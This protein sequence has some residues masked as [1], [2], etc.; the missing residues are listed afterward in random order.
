M[1]VTKSARLQ[2]GATLIEALVAVLIFSIGILAVVGMQAFAVSAVSDA[3]YRADASFLA[4]QALGRLWG[5]PANLSVHAES[6]VD[7][8]GLPQGKR[9]VEISGERAVV[10]I[11]WQPPGGDEHRFVAEAHI[12]ANN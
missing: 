3:K 2:Q 6:D 7:V 4:N 11:R 1:P 12:N 5:D 9:T 10:T 8:A